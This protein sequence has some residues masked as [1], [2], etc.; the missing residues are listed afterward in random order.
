METLKNRLL[1]LIVLTAL[2]SGCTQNQTIAASKS[3][4]M[5]MRDTFSDTW[6]ATDD[7]GRTIATSPA[8]RDGKF[9]GLF[10]FTWHGVHGYD[11][12]Y[13]PVDAGQGVIPKTDHEDY[14]S[15]FDTTVILA[16]DP[17]HRQ[18]GAPE[19]FH[20]WGQSEWGYYLSDD[21][22]VI[23][24]HCQDFVDAGIDVLIVDATNGFTYRDIYLNI[25]R[26]YQEI[27]DSGQPTPQIAFVCNSGH[28]TVVNKIYG[29]FYS[30]NLYPDLWFRWKGKPLILTPSE[31]LSDEIKNFFTLR[32]SWAWS[33]APWFGDEPAP[34]FGDGKDKWPWI[35]Y[36][37]QQPG[38]HESPDKPEHLSVAVA[39]HPMFNIGRSYHKGKQPP[40][41]QYRTSEGA[42]FAEQW[43]RALEVDPEFVLITGWN[44]WTAMRFISK[45]EGEQ[46]AGKPIPKGG[47][48]FVDSYD[49]EFSRDIEPMKGG[50]GDSYYYQMTDFIRQY[51]GV[52][53]LPHSGPARTIAIDG[54]FSEWTTV[55]PEYFDTIGDTHHRDHPGW[56]RI[57]SY[58][59]F[60]GRNDF[61]S[62]KVARDI[63]NM[64]F[65]VR[66]DKPISPSTDKNWM[67]LFIDADAN[68]KTGWKGY[69]YLVNHEIKNGTHSFLKQY[70]PKS[71]SWKTLDTVPSR[72]KGNQLELAVPRKFL[73]LTRDSDVT[74][75]FHWADNITKLGDITEFAQG[76]DSAPI[77]RFNYRY[78]W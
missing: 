23:R 10:F 36:Y 30:K 74:V 58:T 63:R 61:T 26:V 35:D 28:V 72:V 29:E 68:P 5:P 66:T 67:L 62:A 15:P 45:G 11:E 60:T 33:Y 57:K 54:D 27:R 51:K 71:N 19:A 73:K 78:Q 50:Y 38:W 4:A 9:V 3:S 44:E 76:G 64:Y 70:D 46:M 6:V 13:N 39:S 25:C 21:E 31:G 43:Q 77:R 7:L 24:K 37:P 41:G 22:F 34:W 59:N 75:D 48:F 49:Q 14:K 16:Q 65:Y 20:H 52:R 12:A 40:P 17:N 42:H 47:S 53:T 1:T 18:W 32:Q 8:L 55:T 2:F 69:D 56:G